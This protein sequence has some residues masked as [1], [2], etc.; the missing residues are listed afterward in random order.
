MNE[1][2]E[3]FKAALAERGIIPPDKLI[4][5]GALHRCD[6]EDKR[7]KGDA[8]YV[9]HLDGIAAGGFENWRDGFGWQNWRAD[10][11]RA[12][13]PA[14]E[15]AQQ[16]AIQTARDER[17]AEDIKRKTE[18]REVCAHTWNKAKPASNEHPYLVRKGVQSH[19]LR[20]TGNGRLLIPM[21][22]ASGTLH[23]LQFID[24]DGTKRFKTGGKKQG[25]YFPIGKPEG[26]L[27][28]CEGYATGA[29]IH[30]SA[31]Y[32]VAIAF[33]AGNLESVAKA[34]RQ[35]LPDVRMMIC[36]DD[37]W[38]TEGNP[39]LTK[40]RA[41]A[42]SIGAGLSLPVFEAR[43]TGDTDFNDLHQKQGAEAV[44][45]AIEVAANLST[46]QPASVAQGATDAPAT[47]RAISVNLVC[48]STLKPEPIDWL[49]NGWLAAGK[50]HI[51][52]GAPGTGKTTIALSLAA[53]LTCGGWFPDGTRAKQGNVVIWSGEDDPQD[54]LV[55][56]LTLSGADC[57]KVH[58]ITGAIECNERRGFDP[59]RDI[60]PLRRELATIGD[61]RLLIIDPIVSAVSGDSHKNAEVRRSLQPLADLAL[62][63]RCAL[64][65]ITHFS[66]GTGGRDPT[67]RITGS[68]AFGA[69]AR[70]VMVAAKHQEEGED[71]KAGRIFCRAK[72]NIGVD[73]GGFR[74]DLRQEELAT[75]PGVVASSVVWGEAVEGAARELLAVADDAGEGGEGVTLAD[76][77]RVLSD[78]LADAPLPVK[79]IKADADGAGYSWA[80]VRRAQ[81]SLE[82][83][84]VKEGF[85]KSGGWVWKLPN[86][87][88]VLKNLKDAQQNNV[89][90]LG[91][92]EHLK[93]KLTE[94][95][96]P[97]NTQKQSDDDIIEVTI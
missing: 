71:G 83:E 59:S 5:D 63:L 96:N 7:G 30:E 18:A 6:V 56:R 45:A 52:G 53:I 80:S 89:S 44:R 10:I 75:F 39:G 76:V 17:K 25:C 61:V 38:Q 19:G 77:K 20:V 81:K 62:S 78:L 72:S 74:Y 92:F 67:E 58:F 87:P 15:A 91:K 46:G 9:L 3:Q 60:E 43:E 73:D 90:T 27:C 95:V 86:L 88:K 23:S 57:R 69:L 48:A 42:E 24:G 65:G 33:D 16:A 70:V 94:N 51:L 50:M 37:D 12:L 32:A 21:R 11:G 41:A 85:G 97:E 36:A 1:P 79:V 8:A 29:S 26:V 4:A 28:V 54:T 31:G 82:I 64:L 40:A 34:L 84:A 2:I 35:K 13:T 22:D 68:L 66:K 49:W 47:C 55:P 93:E 14:E